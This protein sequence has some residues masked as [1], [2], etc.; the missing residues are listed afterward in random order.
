ALLLPLAVSASA[1]DISDQEAYEIAK[2]AYV[3]AF[4][5]VLQHVTQR[6]RVS[7][8]EPTG[9]VGQAPFNQFSHTRAFTPVDFRAIVRPNVDTL[10][11]VAHLDLGP[12][13]V[14]LS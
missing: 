11:S 7:V 4:P 1:Q 8:A 9:R 10:Y 2:E 5:L 14:V 6:Q 13:P 12:E 3:Y